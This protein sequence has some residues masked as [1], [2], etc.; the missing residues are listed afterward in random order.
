MADSADHLT[1]R[2]VDWTKS[3]LPAAAVAARSLHDTTRDDGVDLRLLGL[4][5]R[6]APGGPAAP[7]ILAL[8]YLVTLRLADP[9]DEQA[10][11]ADLLFAAMAQADFEV[12]EGRRA[13]ELCAALG[14]PVAAGFVLRTLLVRDRPVRKVALVREPLVVHASEMPAVAREAADPGKA[15]PRPGRRPANP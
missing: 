2:L 6:P 9:L 14:L 4:A 5:P 11:L 10:A 12:V 13:A 7:A 1:R 8:D 15:Q 3:V